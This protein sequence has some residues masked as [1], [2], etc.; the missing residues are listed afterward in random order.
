M[1]FKCS[2]TS[3][4]AICDPNKQLSPERPVFGTLNW[5]NNV[6]PSWLGVL[7]L[8]ANVAL[9]RCCLL[10]FVVEVIVQG[11]NL[12][13]GFHSCSGEFFPLRYILGVQGMETLQ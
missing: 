12:Q 13:A 4:T 1:A 6:A 10:S 5:L 11:G 9:L 2:L 7:L 3:G 8:E